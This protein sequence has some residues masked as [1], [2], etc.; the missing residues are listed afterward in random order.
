[1]TEVEWLRLSSWIAVAIYVAVA[2][3]V[4]HAL[5][6][7]NGQRP[8]IRALVVI[9]ITSFISLLALATLRQAHTD[10]EADIRLSGYIYIWTAA[11][12]LILNPLAIMW[13]IRAV[14]R[15]GREND[16]H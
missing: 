9:S 6:Q 13:A 12:A 11:A 14:R 2:A 15:N 16:G 7:A 1:M 5:A 10:N 3:Q 8:L 4:A